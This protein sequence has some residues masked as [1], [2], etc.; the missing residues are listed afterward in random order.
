MT[1]WHKLDPKNMAYKK[2]NEQASEMIFILTGIQ[3]S[4]LQGVWA[5]M[6]IQPVCL[7]LLS[8]FSWHSQPE[9]ELVSIESDGLA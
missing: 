8:L 6:R 5:C 4:A 9:Q 2:I 3:S 7:L 1:N